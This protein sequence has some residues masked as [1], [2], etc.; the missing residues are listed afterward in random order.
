MTLSWLIRKLVKAKNPRSVYVERLIFSH[1]KHTNVYPFTNFLMRQEIF[2]NMGC[3]I[4]DSNVLLV[5][6]AYIIYYL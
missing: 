2:V 6:Y 3:V 5:G 4:K 1:L